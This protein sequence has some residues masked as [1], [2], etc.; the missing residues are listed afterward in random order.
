MALEVLGVFVDKVEE[1]LHEVAEGAV[2]AE[3]G[4]DGEEAWIAAG[5]DFEWANGLRRRAPGG[6]GLPKRM[7]FGGS[8]WSQRDGP[9]EV[10]E[11]V[12]R[13]VN[14]VEAAGGAAEQD[15]AGAR[16]GGSGASANRHPG[17]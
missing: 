17:R 16:F 14:F 11:S 6:N 10:V 1:V 2:G 7:A 3:A 4:D 13:A 9:K 8:E 5:E 15:E 12:V